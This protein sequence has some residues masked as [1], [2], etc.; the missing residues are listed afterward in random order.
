MVVHH[1]NQKL[2]WTIQPLTIFDVKTCSD[3]NLKQEKGGL[4]NSEK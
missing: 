1:L 4:E 3:I 2:Q